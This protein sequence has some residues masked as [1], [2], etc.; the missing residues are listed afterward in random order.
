MNQLSKALMLDPEHRAKIA[1]VERINNRFKT[2]RINSGWSRRPELSIEGQVVA[3]FMT[4][5]NGSG[6][7]Y[8]RIGEFVSIERAKQCIN[9]WRKKHPVT[10]YRDYSAV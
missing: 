4:H 1:R 6:K 2:E 9:K 5:F 7:C 10:S 3:V 8:N